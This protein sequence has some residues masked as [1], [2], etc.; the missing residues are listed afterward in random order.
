MPPPCTMLGRL[1]SFQPAASLCCRFVTI[2][3]A[4][5]ISTPTQW[6]VEHV[7]SV[8]VTGNPRAT[9]ISS[10]L[11]KRPCNLH[12]S[13]R[14]VQRSETA[15]ATCFPAAGLAGLPLASRRG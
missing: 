8:T 4:P 5:L 3:P 7:G 6:P 15:W 1:P 11:W 9:S 12:S 2:R 10:I 14:A 13:W